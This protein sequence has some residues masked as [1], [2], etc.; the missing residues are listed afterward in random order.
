MINA[1]EALKYIP[2]P[3]IPELFPVIVQF[4]IVGEDSLQ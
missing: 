2:P 4:V 1:D 3:S